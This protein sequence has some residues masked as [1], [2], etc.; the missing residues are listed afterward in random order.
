LLRKKMNRSKKN[1]GSMD[2]PSLHHQ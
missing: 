1:D 2:D